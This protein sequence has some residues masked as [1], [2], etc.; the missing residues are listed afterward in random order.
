M[1]SSLD[2][3]I[4]AIRTLKERYHCVRAVDAAHFLGFSKASVSIAL[5]QMR[6][7]GLVE[8]EPDGNLQFTEKGKKRADLLTGRVAFF[9]QMLTDAGVEPSLALKDAVSFSWEMSEASYE[10]FRRIA[11]GQKE[12]APAPY[13]G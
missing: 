13:R 5:R 2:R 11:A 7:Q 8:V 9:R 1:K 10:A 12:T 3:Y 4:Y 6:E